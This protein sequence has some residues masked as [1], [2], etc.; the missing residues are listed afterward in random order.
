ME[1]KDIFVIK[2]GEH[3]LLYAPMDENGW[4]IEKRVAR[5]VA[6]TTRLI[7]MYSMMHPDQAITFEGIPTYQELLNNLGAYYRNP[8]TVDPSRVYFD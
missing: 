1:G 6:T 8:N 3:G 7:E 5:H 2:A 4:P